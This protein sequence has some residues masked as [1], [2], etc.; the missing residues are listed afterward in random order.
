[1]KIE[2]NPTPQ[3]L[4]GIR[5]IIR[6]E[7]KRSKEELFKNPKAYTRKE[8]CEALAMSLPTLDGLIRS[9]KIKAFKE[10][11]KIYI[12]EESISAFLKHSQK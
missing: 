4:E 6:E 11:R 9:G 1:M 2:L 10:G 8:A 7:L 5:N 12:P 3:L